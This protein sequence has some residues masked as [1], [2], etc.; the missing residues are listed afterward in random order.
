MEACYQNKLRLRS[1]ADASTFH[2]IWSAL[3]DFIGVVGNNIQHPRTI[4][5]WSIGTLIRLGASPELDVIDHQ[6]TETIKLL[7]SEL[8]V[9]CLQ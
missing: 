3:T 6:Q 1:A 7:L 9:P 2:N 5:L 8:F 4:E